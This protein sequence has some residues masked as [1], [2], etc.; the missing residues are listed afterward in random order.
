MKRLVIPWLAL[1]G[2]WPLASVAD[3]APPALPRLSFG[4]VPQQ[5]PGRLAQLWTPILNYLGEQ[6][7]VRLDFKTAPDIPTFERRLAAGDYDLAYMNPY[8]YTVFHRHPGYLAFARE[9]DRKLEG[10]LVVRR[11]SPYIG[12]EQLAGQTLVFPAP[13]AFAATV[14]PQAQLKR[15]GIGYTPKYVASHDSVYLA[16]ARGLYPAG[17][18][19]RRTLANAPDEVQAQLRVLWATSRYTAHA[20]AA[21]PRVPRTALERVQRAM[22][23]MHGDP[24]GA[25]LLAAIEFVGIEPARD[26][27]WDDV[28][29]LGIP[30]LDLSGKGP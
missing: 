10:I 7:G 16:V 29:A 21:H 14:L 4:V 6:A 8:H 2:V 27:D 13:A 28:R 12:I 24:R 15:T 26:A 17:G 19:I 25:A 5:A 20:I 11:D 22:L 18:G 30:A 1:L 3:A 9:K 23:A